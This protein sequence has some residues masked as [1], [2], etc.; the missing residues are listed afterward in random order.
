V[1]TCINRKS[2]LP[3]TS[4]SSNIFSWLEY[5][6]VRELLNGLNI[7]NMH[8]SNSSNIITMGSHVWNIVSRNYR[9]YTMEN[10]NISYIFMGG[11]WEKF[12]EDHWSMNDIHTGLVDQDYVAYCTGSFENLECWSVPLKSLLRMRLFDRIKHCKLCSSD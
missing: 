5:F 11:G 10:I 8:K 9:Y 12:G 4:K 6:S 1:N 2:I 7:C 3:L